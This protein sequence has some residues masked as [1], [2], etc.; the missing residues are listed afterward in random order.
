MSNT[1][2]GESLEIR[3]LD[4]EEI[5]ERIMSWFNDDS[6]MQYYTNSKTAISFDTL[7]DAIKKGRQDGNN[8]TYGIYYKENGLCI[9][10]LKIGPINHSH[11]ISDL[12]VLIGDKN[13]HGRGLAIEAI[14]LGNTIAFEQHGIRK[15]FGGMYASNQSSVKAYIRAGWVI[16]SI[17]HG[18]YLN[19]GANEDRIEVGC[20]N[21]TV[22]SEEYIEKCRKLTLEEYLNQYAK[23]NH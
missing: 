14:R 9:G 21:P 18:H 11:K 13:Y 12:V 22:F 10:T 19:N 5:D 15:L 7:V 2:V 3:L 6:L 4:I 17:L 16:E 20:F 1:A 8:F 23:S